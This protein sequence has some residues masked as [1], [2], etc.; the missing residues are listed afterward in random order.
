MTMDKMKFMRRISA[1]CA[2]HQFRWEMV[3]NSII[4][5]AYIFPEDRSREDSILKIMSRYRGLTVER[6]R[7]PYDANGQ[8]CNHLTV[9][10][11]ESLAWLK[12]LNANK[13]KLADAFFQ[14]R[15]HGN[16]SYAK[17][18]EYKYAKRIHAM[19]AFD[20]IYKS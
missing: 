4:P 6:G 7:Y 15:K 16:D 14:A 18:C 19:D 20:A 12:K 1:S 13:S 9:Y 8:Y 10:D 17:Q 2:K 3:R 11:S 5:A